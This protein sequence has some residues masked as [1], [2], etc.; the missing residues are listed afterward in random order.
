MRIPGWA[1]GRPLSSDLYAYDDPKAAAWSVRLAGKTFKAPLE[2]GFVAITRE[3]RPGD[4]V[5]IDLPMSV[6]AVQGNPQIAATR[7]RIAFERGPVVYCV[8]AENHTFVPE[9]VAVS[10]DATV[11]AE[12][13]PDLL[14]GVTVLKIDRDDRAGPITAIPYYAWNNRGLAPMAVWLKRR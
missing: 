13:R 14:G 4:V 5:E 6:H 9:D 10:S 3:W 2:Q 12:A 11:V 7:G 1:Q 8:E